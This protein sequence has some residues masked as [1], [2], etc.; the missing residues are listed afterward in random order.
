MKTLTKKSVSRRNFLTGT[1]T[2]AGLAA[3]S[4]ALP[5]SVAN[6]NHT[7]T[8]DKLPDFIKW[9]KRS[10]LIVHSSKTMETH[11]TEIGSS[12]ITPIRHI[13]IRNNLP[14]LTD[15]QIGNRKDWKVSVAGVKN[16]KTFTLAELQTLGQTTI[17]TVLQC[18]GN[19]RGW[20][21]H[22][23]SGSQ[24]QT[25]AAACVLWTG[26]PVETVIKAC[27]GLAKGAKYMT[28]TGGDAPKNLDPK[29]ATMERSI[30]LKAHKDAI[31]AWEMNGVDIPNAHGGPVRSVTPGYFGVNNVKHLIKLDFTAKESSVRYMK[32][33][34]RISPLGKKGSQYPSCWEMPV[35]SWVTSPSQDGKVKSG[36]VV[37]SGVAFGGT[38]K[39]SNVKVSLDFGKTWKKAKLVGPDLGQFAWRQFV[40]ETTLKPGFYNVAT[41]ASAGEKSQPE[42][43]MDNRRGYAH[44]G[45]KDHSI[46]LDVV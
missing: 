33:S 11:R 41:K 3:A 43:R 24:W 15:E 17:A 12:L 19:G 14:S 21:P 39:L 13:Y 35:K 1:A 29:K 16:P 45:W 2:I 26:V 28:C 42:L 8:T 5:I 40:Y 46:S 31:L 18:S 22:K 32:S 7:E 37:I 6:A 9:K 36:K 30:P 10:A 23:P 34:Y 44:N 20:F 4:S 38:E 25:G 27:G